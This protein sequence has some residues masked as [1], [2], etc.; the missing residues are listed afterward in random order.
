MKRQHQLSSFIISILCIVIIAIST[1]CTSE[2]D[3][4]KKLLPNEISSE[5]SVTQ[6]EYDSSNR[7]IKATETKNNE[8]DITLYIYDNDDNLQKVI[9]S[10]NRNDSTSVII[11]QQVGNTILVKYQ[12]SVNALVDTLIIDK[13]GR[14]IKETRTLDNERTVTNYGY[15]TNGSMVQQEYVTDP[16]KP[17][18]NRINGSINQYSS[19]T[20]FSYDGL[21][22]ILSGVNIK[23][24]QVIYL[25]LGFGYT[26]NY[27]QSKSAYTIRKGKDVAKLGEETKVGS[28][29]YNRENYPTKMVW[30]V[31]E[32]EMI[33]EDVTI[34]IS[35]I[36]AF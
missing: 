9:K 29:F 16:L 14:L 34:N 18:K 25:E 5:N 20:T 2:E 22:G 28:Y 6:Y 33:K 3:V 17:N 12:P 15:S 8:I 7:L 11:F 10:N 23:P 26:G 4:A 35:Y 32:N 19:S 27:T 30:K 31:L 24:W 1:S 21:K 13:A 36:D